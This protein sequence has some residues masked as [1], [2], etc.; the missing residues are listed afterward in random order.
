MTT[1]Q[2]CDRPIKVGKYGRITKHSPSF[3]LVGFGYSKC[4]GSG[5]KSGHEANDCLMYVIACLKRRMEQMERNP[6]STGEQHD[7]VHHEIK[8]MEEKLAV[9]TP[10]ELVADPVVDDTPKTTCQICARP[11]KSASGLIAHHGYRRPHYRSGWQT[12]SCHGAR[13]L[14]YEESCDLLP[15]YIK[16]IE[17]FV[18]REEAALAE[19]LANPPASFTVVEK[20]RQGVEVRNVVDRPADFKIDEAYYLHRSYGSIFDSNRREFQ[21]NIRSGKDELSRLRDRLAAW[22][23]PA[24]VNAE[25]GAR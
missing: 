23:P 7:R 8:R 25:G 21:F 6:A 15:P 18:A 13:S 2:I 20:N 14:P 10:K 16:G 22:V 11:I 19:M 3:A 9:W 17:D 12:A 4:A 24:A 1:C 5:W